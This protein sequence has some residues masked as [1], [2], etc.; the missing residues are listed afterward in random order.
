MNIV[1]SWDCTEKES[2]HLHSRFL[3]P[4]GDAFLENLG[5]RIGY[6]Y[7]GKRQRDG[8]DGREGGRGVGP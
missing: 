1:H 2:P 6:G 7:R 3:L 4:S 5:P 8:A